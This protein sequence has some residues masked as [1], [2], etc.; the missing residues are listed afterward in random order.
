M[1]RCLAQFWQNNCYS[2]PWLTALGVYKRRTRTTGAIHKT[3]ADVRLRLL[4]RL[5]SVKHNSVPTDLILSVAAQIDTLEVWQPY[6]ASVSAMILAC[7][8]T[9]PT[10]S[11]LTANKLFRS[12]ISRAITAHLSLHRILASLCVRGLCGKSV[13]K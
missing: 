11:R 1:C 12:H 8:P 4:R 6:R 10:E 2:D 7:G 5:G 13:S 9:H 3:S